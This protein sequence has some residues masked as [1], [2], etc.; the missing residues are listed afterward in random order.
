MSEVV[1]GWAAALS[2]TSVI[3][4]GP[5][6]FIV[7]DVEPVEA[8]AF[9]SG[10]A[11][12]RTTTPVVMKASGMDASGARTTRQAWCLPGEPEW[13]VYVEGNLRRKAETLGL[14]PD[15]TLEDVTWAGPK[16]SFAVSSASGPGGKKPG[17][18]VE[19]ALSGPPETLSALHSWGV[20]QANSA[21]MGWISS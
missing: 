6:A 19:V 5:A 10:R 4:W 21:G 18:C 2:S 3:A 1:E 9:P 8:P 12:F 15:L 17:A 16:R 11:V 7:D 20:G 14:D 13:D